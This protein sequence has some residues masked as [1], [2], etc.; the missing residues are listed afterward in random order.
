VKPHRAA[1]ISVTRSDP[2]KRKI[3]VSAGKHRRWQLEA[4]VGSYVRHLREVAAGR[5]ADAGADARAP[6]RFVQ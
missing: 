4:S 2:G 6:Y 1:L 3:I 5:G